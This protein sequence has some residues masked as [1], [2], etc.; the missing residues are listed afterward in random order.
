MMNRTVYLFMLMFVWALPGKAFQS[1]VNGQSGSPAATASAAPMAQAGRAMAIPALD[2]DV[3][4]DPAWGEASLLTGLWQVTPSEGAPASEN[5]EIRVAYTEDTFYVGVVNYDRTPSEIVTTDARRDASLEETD[6]FLMILDTYHDGQNGFVFGTNPAGAEYDGQVTEEG[7]FN[8]NWDGSWEVRTRIT[9]IGWSAEFAIPL[10]TLRYPSRDMQTWGANFQRN[11]RRRNETAFWAP[12][13]RQYNLYRLSLA[14]QLTGLEIPPPRNLQLMPYVLGQSRQRGTEATGTRTIGTYGGDIKFTITPSLALDVTVNT[15][16]AQVEVD[17]QQI[18]LDRFSLFFPEKRPFF[19]ENAGLFSVGISRE[20]ELFFSRRIGIGPNGSE[21][22]IAGGG[23][24]TGRI[25]TGLDI[26]LLNIQT[27]AVPGLAPSNNFGVARLRR[28]LPNRSS[29]GAIFISRQAA[30]EFAGEDDH[31]RSYGMDGRLGVGRNGIVSAFVAKTAT[32]GLSGRDYAYELS[33]TYSRPT[34]RLSAGYANVGDNFNPEVGFLSRGAF[35]KFNAQMFTYFRVTNFGNFH[36][37]RPHVLYTGYWNHEGF[38]QTGN[39]HMDSHWELR[40]GHEFHTG[41]NVTKQGVTEPF[42]IFPGVIVPPGTY[43]HV[44]AQP[45]FFTN[46]G[47]P[48]S[49]NFDGVFGGFFGGTR[50]QFRPTVRL[51]IGDTFSG[52]LSLARN[53]I[54]LPWGKFNTNLWSSRLSYSFTPRIFLQGLIQYNDRARIW[55]SN[56]RFGLLGE[57][58]TGLFVVYNDTQGLTGSDLLRA[59]RSLTLKFSR[60]FNVFN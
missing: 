10:R 4:G 1:G 24:L 47:A 14:G 51:R 49:F 57:A 59:D 45:V 22:P 34:V 6:S 29:V 37:L 15:D 54:D 5:T 38:Q 60:V 21:I 18:N 9:E 44:E 11:I 53:N 3:L 56:V 42:E 55:S 7:T 16:F 2:G 48:L 50:M 43:D 23:R 20:A 39:L 36:E 32:P 19:L 31:N 8:A 33:S 27:E 25:G 17:D 26:G 12:L 40:S 41:M 30:G 13:P 35:R 46:Q 58:N 28:E 52:Q